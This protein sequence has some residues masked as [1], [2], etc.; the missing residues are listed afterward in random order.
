MHR[1]LSLHC[2]GDACAGLLPLS[3]LCA[4]SDAATQQD[5]KTCSLRGRRP[6]RALSRVQVWAAYSP[7]KN[8]PEEARAKAA[9]GSPSHSATT[10]EL[11][12]YHAN[13]RCWLR[14]KL[15]TYRAELLQSPQATHWTATLLSAVRQAADGGPL[16]SAAT[17]E[18]VFRLH[19]TGCLYSSHAL[20]LC[21]LQN[22]RACM[23]AA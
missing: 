4:G 12:I 14:V 3:S 22:Q 19:I 10:G 5:L 13:C 17:R 11:D 9:A 21:L 2:S 16:H 15:T 18:L 20:L 23:Q 8:S 7:V 1:R 6:S